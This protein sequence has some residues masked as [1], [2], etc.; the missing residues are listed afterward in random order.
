M[1][2][3]LAL[4]AALAN[5]C[6]NLD[7][8]ELNLHSVNVTESDIKLNSEYMNFRLI[9]VFSINSPDWLLIYSI[10]DSHEM[11]LHWVDIRIID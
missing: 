2:P 6:Q 7:R 10:S 9:N 11:L 4:A 3:A 5:F 1:L 8:R